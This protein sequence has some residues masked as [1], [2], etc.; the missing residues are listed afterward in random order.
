MNHSKLSLLVAEWEFRRYFKWKDQVLG[1]MFFVVT[2]AISYGVSRIMGGERRPVTVATSGIELASPAGGR[3][4]LVPAPADS[5]AR[6]AMLGDGDA[7]GILTRRGDGTFDLLVEKDPRYLSELRALVANHVGRERLAAS[8]LKESELARIL[9]PPE[10]KV[11]FTDP[12][13]ARTGK[14][15]KIAAG[16][17]Q[18]L[19]LLAVFTSM[20][21]LLTGITGEKQLRVTESI[22]AIIPPQAWIDGKILGI[23]AYSLASIC[24]MVVGGLLLAFAAKLAWGFSLPDV[25][26]RPGVILVLIV[27]SILGLLLWNAF[28]AAFASTIDDPNT[29]TRTSIM[30]LPMLPV[31]MTIM[32]LRDPDDLTARILAVFPLT[33]PSAMPARLILSNPT[34][35]EILVSVG[36]LAGTIW[37]V[38]RM[39][40][41]VFE[42]GM[43]MYGK[44]PTMREVLRWTSAK[45]RRVNPGV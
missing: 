25:L 45:S 43:L 13:R 31:V 26:V 32:V 39:A 7:Q 19:V 1:L 24:N 20:A 11:H 18:G 9:A 38:R 41:R 37:L 3:V 16:A 10:V 36:L 4:L 12:N 28:F 35:L 21:Y 22:T 42:I 17:F 34:V 30:F 40:G 23:C 5:G 6:V 33:S 2:G 44:E 27:Y 29:S 15:E 8:G 14:A